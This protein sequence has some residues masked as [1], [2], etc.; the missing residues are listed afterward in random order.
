MGESWQ[1]SGY[2]HNYSEI[3]ILEVFNG[4]R[5]FERLHKPLFVDIT[6]LCQRFWSNYGNIRYAANFHPFNNVALFSI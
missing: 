5:V 2:S 3:Y 1:H 4:G 6:S